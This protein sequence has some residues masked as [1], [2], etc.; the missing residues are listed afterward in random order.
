VNQ[1]LLLYEVQTVAEV[2]ATYGLSRLT[3][4][5]AL[6]S[7]RLHGRQSGATWLI[8][9]QDAVEWRRQVNQKRKD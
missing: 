3:V 8:A 2:A 1:N 6:K 4:H 7:G 9:R 5:S